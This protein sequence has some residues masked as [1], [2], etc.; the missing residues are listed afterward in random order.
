LR[1]A[2]VS[3]ILG[4]M[5]DIKFIREN[6]DL[7]A[8]GAQKKHIDFNVDELLAIDD[9]RRTLLIDV[10]AMRGKQNEIAQA[11]PQAKDS[12]ERER[13]I[14]ESKIL[15]DVLQKKEEELGLV[16]KKWQALMVQV[17]N[18][19]D[20]SVPEGATDGDNVEVRKWGEIPKFD[21]TPKTH[22]ELMQ[23]LKM[24]DLER[25]T[26]VAGFRGYFLTGDGVRLQFALWNFA[27]DFFAKKGG[28]TPMIVPSLLR[29]EPF[30][31]TGY[32]PQSEEDL[33]KTQD[34]EYLSGTAEV[35]TMGYYMDEVL[36][37][38][39]LP[40]KMLAF[41]PAFRREAGSHGKDTKGIMRVHEFYKFEQVVLCEASHEE[42]VKLH[43][44]LTANAEELMQALGLPYHT[45]VNCGGDL[46]LGQVKKYDIEAWMAGEGAYRETHSAS[47][48]HDFQTRRLNI[49]Y[50][51][52]EGKMKFAHSLNNTALSGRPMIAL[53]E[54]YQNADGSITVPE[55]LRPYMGKDTIN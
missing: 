9:I 33:Y 49:R 31:G 4:F 43:E 40:I 26:K 28:F 24:L 32:L 44:E 14:A 54:N 47:Y 36:E 38:K 1:H 10:E 2:R 53:V 35:A 15:K 30:M 7:I 5:L 12:E 50:R 41:S 27:Q 3:G 18:I 25:G 45:V 13:L 52:G 37:K 46:G 29:R 39:D 8:V 34:G 51:D 22:I 16:M 17:P 19:P 48:F 20:M 11:V 55:V 42:S 6:K 23:N 21:F